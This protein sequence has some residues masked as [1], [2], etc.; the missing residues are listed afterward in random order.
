ML[1]SATPVDLYG[2]ML[3]IA[4]DSDSSLPTEIKASAI[5]AISDIILMMYEP[6]NPTI[7]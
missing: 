7:E 2:A 4:I 6:Q 3:V 1:P 5:Q